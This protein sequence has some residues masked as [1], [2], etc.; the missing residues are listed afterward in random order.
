[1]EKRISSRLRVSLFLQQDRICS[2][3]ACPASLLLLIIMPYRRTR[4]KQIFSRRNIGERIGTSVPK[5]YLVGFR[6]ADNFD[7]RALQTID[8]T[9]IQKTTTNDINERQR[10]IVNL[11]GFKIYIQIEN[12]SSNFLTYNIAVIS[13]KD[14]RTADTLLFFRDGTQDSR[15]SDFSTSRSNIEFYRYPI[16]P[17]RWTVLKHNRYILNPEVTG[18]STTLF[19]NNGRSFRTFKWWVPVKRQIRYDS[20]TSASSRSKVFLVWWADIWGAGAGSA[21]ITN[22]ARTTVFSHGVFRE[23]K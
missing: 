2:L 22:I 7:S 21:P 13:P 18:Q 17:D 23:P 12:L 14:G 6:S 4:K 19:A 3:P 15:A 11:R 16:N 9:N 1:M 10:N 20:S 5:E 8:L